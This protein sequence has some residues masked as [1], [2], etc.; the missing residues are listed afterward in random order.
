MNKKDFSRERLSFEIWPRADI[1]MEKK[2]TTRV[3][4]RSAIRGA[5]F[6]D[7]KLWLLTMFVSQGQVS[8]KTNTSSDVSL[9]ITMS[10]F[11]AVTRMLGG[12]VSS[13]DIDKHVELIKM[14]S[15]ENFISPTRFQRTNFFTFPFFSTYGVFGARKLRLVSKCSVLFILKNPLPNGQ[16]FREYG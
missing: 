12:T 15:T 16:Y 1:S 11:S 9:T 4:E 13:K 5:Y 7:L 3:R 2:E 14:K 8:S 6:S 10:G